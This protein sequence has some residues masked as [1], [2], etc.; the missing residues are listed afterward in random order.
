MHYI[1]TADTDIGITKDTNQDSLLIKHGRY[2]GGEI[3]MAV[4][5]DGM[6][7]LAKG[8]V[9]SA[10]VI[11]RFDKWFDEE[12]PFELEHP[13]MNVIGAKWSH[14][15][16]ELNVLILKYGDTL[17]M[18]MGTT[19]TGVLFIGNQFVVAHIG[20]SRLYKIDSNV[21]QLTEDHTYVAREINMGRMTPEQAKSD[22]RRNMLLQCVGASE[23]IEP[24]IFTERI[25][26]GT[27]MLC[28]DGFRHEITNQE[29]YKW[30]NP[31]KLTDK[32][33]MHTNARYLIEQAKK[34]KENDNI[35]VILIKAD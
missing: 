4:V 34:R 23:S 17:Q 5:C 8:E 14:I 25:S 32:Q 22:N 12:L 6:G 18:S 15:L 31:D 16:K 26:V 7:G 35:S 10:T 3:I 30:L 21:I 29:I 24:Q 11:K 1:A 28:S 13:D 33:A 19:F 20:D 2:D 9:A 27:Y